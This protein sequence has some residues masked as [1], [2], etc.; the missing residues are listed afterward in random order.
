MYPIG[1]PAPSFASVERFR[2]FSSGV[3]SSRVPRQGLALD[4]L[5]DTWEYQ[6]LLPHPVL[7]GQLLAHGKH[8]NIQYSTLKS[9]GPKLRSLIIMSRMH[10]PLSIRDSPCFLVR[11]ES[12]LT[13]NIP[14]F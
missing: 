6:S 10:S 3:L 14:F 5:A 12:A 2:R 13:E 1:C 4:Y 7:K 9:K 11:D 8:P